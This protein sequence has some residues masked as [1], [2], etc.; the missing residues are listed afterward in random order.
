MYKL[1]ATPLD[2]DGSFVFDWSPVVDERGLFS[3]LFCE[4]ELRDQ[5]GIVR[6]FVQGN[7]S[8]NTMRGTL[9]GLH[10]LAAPKLEG[11]LVRCL[12]GEVQD[13]F[14]DLRLNSPTRLQYVNITLSAQ[15]GKMIYVPPGCAHG[16]LTLSQEADVFY[17][18][19]EHYEKEFDRALAWND[20]D[21]NLPWTRF[22]EYQ[23]SERD[24]LAPEFSKFEVSDFLEI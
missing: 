22:D 21:L 10:F 3:R 7:Y 18:V 9:R 14:V 1:K 17:L 8:T 20:P 4:R 16:Y 15:N 23:L 11:K 19:Q 2:I 12:R 13:I 5:C 24:R 6:P